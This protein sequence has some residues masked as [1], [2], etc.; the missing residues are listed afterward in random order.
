MEWALFLDNLNAL[1]EWID[2]VDIIDCVLV[3]LV[4]KYQ[5]PSRAPG[6]L[7][8]EKGHVWINHPYLLE[9]LPF[10][11]IGI[12]ALRK[13]LKH[14]VDIGILEREIIYPLTEKGVRKNACYRLSEAFIEMC[15]YFKTIQ[16]IHSDKNLTEQDKQ[17]KLAFLLKEKPEILR[18]VSKYGTRKMFER[19]EKGRFRTVTGY[20][21]QR[22]LFTVHNGNELPYIPLLD[23]SS[24]NSASNFVQHLP[25]TQRKPNEN[26]PESNSQ[27]PG[28]EL[29]GGSD[30]A[31]DDQGGRS[32][33][34]L[35]E[36]RRK[37]AEIPDLTDRCRAIAHY[38]EIGLDV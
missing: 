31:A 18:T 34:E 24:K 4:Q 26:P 16:A 6:L 35:E 15:E 7:R 1:N 17:H 36:L 33:E 25:E 3:N 8:T 2:D 23:P 19:D 11:K 14:L 38:R 30:P 5:D 29:E 10:L 37:I 9:Q 32:N 21:T 27:P 22:Y 28:P 20:R 12:E 13:R